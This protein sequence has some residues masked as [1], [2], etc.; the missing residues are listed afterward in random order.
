MINII[1][2]SYVLLKNFQNKISYTTH[3][4]VQRVLSAVTG[5]KGLKHFHSES[6]GREEVLSYFYF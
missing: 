2:I 6:K 5:K 3:L 4:L 1:N